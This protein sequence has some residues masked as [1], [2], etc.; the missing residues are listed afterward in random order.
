M[1][2]RH[3]LEHWSSPNGC[4]DGCPACEAESEDNAPDSPSDA[5]DMNA[6]REWNIILGARDMLR[7][8]AK[9]F[10]A[11]N[12]NGHSAMADLH[13][14]ALDEHSRLSDPAA[15]LQAMREALQRAERQLA[16]AFNPSDSAILELCR[17]ETQLICNQIRAALNGGKDQS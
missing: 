7:E 1:K 3:D 15:E 2:T 5:A 6:G 16:I 13:A 4:A 9:Q 11:T 10:R 12:D 8:C 17:S 14:D